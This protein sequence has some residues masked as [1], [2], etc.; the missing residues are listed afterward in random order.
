MTANSE[1]QAL[2]ATGTIE[3][4]QVPANGLT[5]GKSEEIYRKH[6]QNKYGHFWAI[7]GEN[8]FK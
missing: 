8:V 4:V 3:A 6:H 5:V 1:L 7:Y 2:W